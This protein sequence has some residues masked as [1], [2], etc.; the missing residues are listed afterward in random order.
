MKK[1]LAILIALTLCLSFAALAEEE[2]AI[3]EVTS[4]V[5]F[6]AQTIALGDTGLSI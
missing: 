3:P 6:D 1:V 5:T 4:E 2:A